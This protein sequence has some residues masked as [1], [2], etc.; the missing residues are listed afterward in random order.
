MGSSKA[1]KDS[2]GDEPPSMEIHE[3]AFANPAVEQVNLLK[4][5]NLG[6]DYEDLISHA[7]TVNGDFYE[8]VSKWSAEEIDAQAV[9]DKAYGVGQYHID[10]FDSLDDDELVLALACAIS[11]LLVGQMEDTCYYEEWKPSYESVASIMQ[12]GF[13]VGIGFAIEDCDGMYDT[14]YPV[15]P[16]KPDGE[17]CD[18]ASDCDRDFCMCPAGQEF[19]DTGVNPCVDNNDPAGFTCYVDRG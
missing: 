14:P 6:F 11:E 2:S 10:Y 17:Y 13:V 9:F 16:G 4:T 19:C 15:C 7:A 18:G 5:A 8:C 12:D 1:S 3:C